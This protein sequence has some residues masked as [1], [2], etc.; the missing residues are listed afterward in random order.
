MALKSNFDSGR[1][2]KET[3]AQ[4]ESLYSKI[5][6]AFIYAGETF[7]NNA[8]DQMQDHAMGTYKD[9]T[10]NLRNSIGYFIFHNGALVKEDSNIVTNKSIVEQQVKPDGFQLIGI[11]GMDYASYVE[12][13]GYNVISY[14]A[15]VCIVDLSTYLEKLEVIEK[16]S[17]A[18]TE[19]TFIPEELPQNFTVNG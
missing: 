15:D 6:N 17:A 7:V 14:Q 19:E 5:L 12:S 2:Q 18:R 1:I 8:R 10:G 16:G 11:A 9:V 4:A 13:K 3:Q